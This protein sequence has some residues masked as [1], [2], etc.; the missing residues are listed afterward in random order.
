[1]GKFAPNRSGLYDTT[2]HVDSWTRDCRHESYN[3]APVDGRA[4]TEG[5]CDRR[6][7]RSG[8]WDSAGLRATYR[9]FVYLTSSPS[10]V[11]FRLAR[12]SD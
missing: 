1:V 12:D 4:W 3:G 2:G 7:I 10:D 9:L 11:G 6:V 8:F 5:A